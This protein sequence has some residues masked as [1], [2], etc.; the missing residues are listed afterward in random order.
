MSERAPRVSTRSKSVRAGS[1][2]APGPARTRSV[3]I[4]FAAGGGGVPAAATSE[5]GGDLPACWHCQEGSCAAHSASAAAAAPRRDG[6]FRDGARRVDFALAFGAPRRGPDGVGAARFSS[7]VRRATSRRLAPPSSVSSSVLQLGP[8]R[9]LP[10]GLALQ[11]VAEGALLPSASTTTMT[12]TQQPPPGVVTTSSFFTAATAAASSSTA[13]ASSPWS[14]PE[15]G[16][17]Q[18][19]RRDKEPLPGGGVGGDA[20]S[21]DG[22]D[23]MVD[24][25]GA[26]DVGYI[27]LAEVHDEE[28]RARRDEFEAQLLEAGLEL[29]RDDE[30]RRHGGTVY[31]R[32]H[33]PWHVL[34]REAE[35]LKLKMPTKKVY[36]VRRNTRQA[37]SCW[38]RATALLRPRTPQSEREARIKHLSLPFSRDKEHLFD[39]RDKDTYFTSSQRSKI[40]R[41]ILKRA[42]VTRGKHSIGLTRL[43]ASGVYSA[44]YPLHDG[45]YDVTTGPGND[46][47]VLYEEWASYGVFYKYQPID[48]IRKYFGEKIGLYFA[49]LGVYTALLIPVSALGVVV[50]AYGCLTL[51]YD[52]PST[53]MC[54]RGVNLT[55]C[56]LCDRLCDYWR[57]DSA[58]GMARAS[59]LFDNPA[60]VVFSVVMALWAAMFMEH[61]KRHQMQLNYHWDMA[62]FEEEEDA[63]RVEYEMKLREVCKGKEGQA[64]HAKLT[65]RDRLPSYCLSLSSVLLMTGVTFSVLV[66]IILYRVSVAAAMAVSPN[67]AT[68]SGSR[69]VVMATAVL[70]NLVLILVL[71]EVYAAVARALTVMEVPRTDRTFE[72]R[73]IFKLFLLKFVNSYT[74]IFYVAFFK[75]RF[76]GRPGDYLYTFHYFRME[77]CAP[78]GCLMELCIQLSIIML[79]KQLLQNNLFEVGVPKIKK[80]LRSMKAKDESQKSSGEQAGRRAASTSGRPRPRWER[81]QELEPFSGLTPEYMEMIIQFGFVT[82]FVASFPLAP[83]FALLNNVIEIRLDAKKFITE[84]RRPDAHRAKDI[85]IWYNL[86][87]GLGKLAVIINAFVIAMTSDFVPRLVY[88]FAYS[89]D[90]S[91]R[92]FVENSLS[93]FNTTH[94][95]EGRRPPDDA[96]GAPPDLVCRYKDYREPPWSPNAYEYTRQY[97][98]LLAARLGFVIL[99]QNLVM[100]LSDFVD[101]LIPDVPP[102]LALQMKREKAVLVHVLLREE[103]H[104]HARQQQLHQ[105]LHQ[106]P[107]PPPSSQQQ[108]QQQSQQQ[109][110]QQPR[111]RYPELDKP[112]DRPQ[113]VPSAHGARSSEAAT[114]AVARG[115]PPSSADGGPPAHPPRGPA[116]TTAAAAVGEPAAFPSRLTRHAS[117]RPSG[118]RGPAAGGASR[119]SV[120]RKGGSVR[121]ARTAEPA[122]GAGGGGGS[123]R[124]SEFVS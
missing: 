76:M 71:D 75:G 3:R 114:A 85:G 62:G 16:S 61:W 35:L 9:R 124:H 90:G 22:S 81:D 53:E 79:G 60:T 44:A 120:V 18:D 47:K 66:G 32:L 63:A 123:R 5:T 51:H 42:V 11:P 99:F 92:G 107:Q 19:W 91:L 49:W 38:R 14:P 8:E 104:A 48:L 109:Q 30:A 121:A 41:E 74:P 100:F 39:I 82:L 7:S 6:F 23:D 31:V 101:W 93:V 21:R 26:S 111:Q 115:G 83:L 58:C 56:P 46:R 84:L 45:D 110:Q 72:E 28:K 113:E 102:A 70:I 95:P 25:E 24:L 13:S 119:A 77:E 86:L 105:K 116:P 89:A 59:H 27:P 78:G 43:L 98:A 17:D 96:P 80:L 69:A 4:G 117:H 112:P 103:A 122:G 68:R 54:E 55:M 67:E 94:F 36:E 1:L 34:T 37:C 20:T 106:Q 52:I 33:A 87:R 50:F 73:L 57:L 88:R 64:S 15:V 108:Q 97:W 118:A 12:T 2:R 29:E 40:V 10:S 65:W